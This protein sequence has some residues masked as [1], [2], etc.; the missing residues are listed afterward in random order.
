MAFFARAAKEIPPGITSDD[1]R[2]I[3][4]TIVALTCV[5]VTLNR[6]L[7]PKFAPRFMRKDPFLLAFELTCFA[8][9][10]YCA[11]VGTRGW[12]YD[13]NVGYETP[14]QRLHKPLPLSSR[15]MILCNCAFQIWDFIISLRHAQ[16]NSIEMLMHHAL[17]AALCLAGLH[18]G[19]GQYYGLFFMG[20]TE[21]SSLP[22]VWVDLGKYYPELAK[23]YSGMD[24][25]AK[26]IF[27]L[28]F[29]AVRDVLFMKHSIT[30]WKDSFA[31]LAAGTAKFPGVTK[32]FLVTNLFFNVLQIAW[33]K[34]LL[35][36]LFELIN[37]G[38][39]DEADKDKE[40]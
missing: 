40:E 13:L 6:F 39:K 38:G 32:A 21:T 33:T 7:C 37:G 26:V 34:K 1:V 25:L 10:A 24:L 16:L 20:V 17:A 28:M 27:G 23:R 19:F 18:I 9:L 30:L 3:S 2:Y 15:K 8:P 14:H 5:F 12:L 31:V 36:G 22:L 11:Y 29:I 4:I 35:D